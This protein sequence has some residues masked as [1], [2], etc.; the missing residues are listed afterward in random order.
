MIP[1]KVPEGPSQPQTLSTNA[2]R[3]VHRA[4]LR[5]VKSG[6]EREAIEGGQIDAVVDPES[7]KV[8]LLPEAQSTL[9][10]RMVGLQSRFG[11]AFDWY[12]KQDEQFRF[13]PS[14]LSD[15]GQ[16]LVFAGASVIGKTLWE[17]SVDNLSEAEWRTHRQ[18]LAWH[19]EFRDLEIRCIA[20]DGQAQY[21]AISGSP[22]LNDAHQ[23]TGYRGIARDITARRQSDIAAQI[24]N[25]FAQAALEA[26]TTPIGVL[27]GGGMVLAAN[28]AWRIFATNHSGA[29]AHVVQGASYL[30]ALDDSSDPEPIDARAIA[31]GIRQVLSGER[32]VFRYEQACAAIR[33][34]DGPRWS[35]LCV[36]RVADDPFARAVV[37][38]ED[39]TQ[40]VYAQELLGL[41]YTVARSLSQ[42]ENTSA[43]LKTTIRNICD[44]LG[45]QCGRYFHIDTAS[46]MLSFRESWGKPDDTI[47]RFLEQSSGLVFRPDAGLA[48]RVNQT[49]QPYWVFEDVRGAV[50]SPMALAPETGREGAFVF[51]VTSSEEIVG[52][53]AFSG[54]MIHQPD[55][56]LLEA[57]RSIGS[58]VGHY[59][60]R[61]EALSSLRQSEERFRRFTALASDW[62]WEQ[63]S[64]FRFTQCVGGGPFSGDSALAKT[65]WQLP[66]VV[67]AEGN[68]T[69]HI[70][71]LAARWSYCDFKFSIALEDGGLACYCISGEPMYDDAGRFVGYRGTGLDVTVR[72]REENL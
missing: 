18:Q 2:E 16:D 21:L 58:D 7:G 68:W 26:L 56:R 61:E 10:E 35:A 66:G 49:R 34:S 33:R 47:E 5:L 39:V 30:A 38:R 8:I 55:D 65:L 72:Q 36:T 20:P 23:L 17:L 37:A 32:E 44:V 6:P 60:R 52:V 48:G 69:T 31:A 11:L 43:G 67:P 70:S 4:I 63:D 9:I 53:F 27:D 50:V 13:V 29:G 22:I 28:T 40:R 51:P 59:L 3:G 25:R 64:E 57:A 71:Q 12:W 42:S 15:D 46:G 19:A 54:H 62:Y 14:P 24:S 1:T 41:K 45:W